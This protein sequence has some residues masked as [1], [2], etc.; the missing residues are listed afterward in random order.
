MDKVAFRCCLTWVAFFST[1]SLAQGQ[2]QVLYN[3]DIRPILSN[4]CFFCHGFDEGKREAGLRLDT[5]EGATEADSI[6]PGK[7]DESELIAR[8]L[9]DDPDSVM[10]PSDSV[11]SL[12]DQ[13]KDLLVRWV[14]Q[15]GD[16][17]EHWAYRELVRPQVPAVAPELKTG[18]P[19]DA[20][21]RR[22]IDAHQVT[23]APKA[24]PRT[25]L[26]RLSYDLRGLP[27]SMAEVQTFQN[28]PSTVTWEAQVEKWLTSLECA[29]HQAVRWLDLVR[30][31]DSSG[32][33]SDEP[34][35]SGL[36]RSYVI[37]AFR[38]NMPFDQFTREQLAGD[39]LPDRNDRTLVAS[40]YNRLIKTNC[41]A[42]GIEDEALH[43]IKGEHVRALGTVWLGA[44]T[45]CAECH[46]HKYDPIS[47]RDYYSL[48]AFFDDL[49][50][51]G[52]YD[53][54]DRRM[55]VHYV[56]DN[57]FFDPSTG[58]PKIGQ[59]PE[60]GP[61][62]NAR[63][64]RQQDDLLSNQIEQLRKEV[65]SAQANAT[66]IA[67]WE[68]STL[69]QYN[70]QPEWADFAWMPA[71]L[72]AARVTK[73]DYQQVE[74]GRRVDAAAGELAWH[75]AGEVMTGFMDGKILPGKKND[76]QVFTEVWVDPAGPPSSIGLQIIHGAYDR[77]GWHAGYFTTYFWGDPNDADVFL[78]TLPH[79]DAKYV[80]PM[81]DIPPAT[82]TDPKADSGTENLAKRNLI[83]L[84]IPGN[85]IVSSPHQPVGMAWAQ[86][87]GSVVWGNSGYRLQGDKAFN[88]QL[89]ESTLRYWWDL[90]WNR[91]DREHRM[92]LVIESI[93][94]PVGKR[95]QV[96][97]DVIRYAYLEAQHP[98][99][100][101]QLKKLYAELF[102][103]RQSAHSLA[104][105]SK[106]GKRKSTRVRM[107]G[108]FMDETGPVVGPA[109]PEF[110]GKLDTDGPAS[111]LDL[112]HWLTSP[113]NPITPRV[114]VNRMWHQFFGRGISETLEDAGNQGDWPSHP[115]LL[116]WLAA[117]LVES[118]W[119]MRHIIRLMVTSD[120][121][122]LSS[123]GSAELVSL[124]PTNRLHARQSR[125]RHG[126]EEIRDS[127]LQAAGLLQ[128][129]EQI[130]TRSFFPYQPESYWEKSNK[131]MF[132]SRYLIWATDQG[133]DQYQRG[134]YTFWKRQN[135]HPSM[136]AFDAPT[137]QECTARRSV[138]NTPGQ[139]LALLND[140]TF[141]E[142]SRALAQR[143]LMST[144]TSSDNTST[145]NADEM[146]LRKLF[147]YALQ[148]EPTAE[149]VAELTL[150]LSTWQQHY[151]NH[152]QQA[153][154]V[155]KIGQAPADSSL[156]PPQ[157]AAWT[158]VCRVVLN[159]H[160]FLTRS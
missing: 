116:D 47:A 107:G 121:Y 118:G 43:A 87:G 139:A 130:P 83:R 33:V 93:K 92:R 74:D 159:L 30:W 145:D 101:Q 89:A 58:G 110:M 40:G 53:P 140:P 27:P 38:N 17:Q 88:A 8:I 153:N 57:D 56:Y 1:F 55:P 132:G 106:A 141:V 95:R 9:S 151:D 65:Y 142:A 82:S 160:E 42:G 75:M 29:E 90:P 115:E 28:D 77:V 85:K 2:D 14:R 155:L 19:I 135:P 11:Y 105:V 67:K 125:Y 73:G 91:D 81:G 123:H 49:I 76:R 10:P 108:N 79:P 96:H 39:L 31:A 122:Q 156:S 36:Y 80:V 137:R 112:A 143:V 44:T 21:L 50:E 46:D 94:Q 158:A 109:I 71:E 128:L 16:Y 147:E 59:P 32:M 60:Q 111:R 5:F 148:R 99:Q 25:R 149:E 64:L 20:F 129:T 119:D 78:A 13:Q 54:G 18:N 104:L 72:P 144:D 102:H 152:L 26:R 133:A 61:R 134:L 114:L 62:K 84:E 117:E 100:V 146:R 120:A 22:T 124:D 154:E 126:A 48:A 157:F 69:A 97:H 4:H 37:Q 34:I 98:R 52:V 24:D 68:E 12:T 131:I 41:E 66:E 127:A 23:A 138:T 6:V 86:I 63:Q 136:L 51:A 35:D 103:V 3:R 70:S 150:Q 45:G 15:G 7:P 113:E